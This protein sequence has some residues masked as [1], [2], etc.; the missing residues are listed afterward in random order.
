MPIMQWLVAALGPALVAVT[1]A[2]LSVNWIE[3]NGDLVS[4]SATAA[5]G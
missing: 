1:G 5:P 2:L 3:S 4:A